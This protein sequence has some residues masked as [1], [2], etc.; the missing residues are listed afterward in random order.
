[1]YLKNCDKLV[2]CGYLQGGIGRTHDIRMLIER[3]HAVPRV[4][5]AKHRFRRRY[6]KPRKGAI[7]EVVKLAFHNGS[8]GEEL[9]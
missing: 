9:H 2:L 8:P 1:M 7:R 6:T 4:T 5:L 3:Q